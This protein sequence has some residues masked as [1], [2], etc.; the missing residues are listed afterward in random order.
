MPS[1]LQSSAS[2][3]RHVADVSSRSRATELQPRLAR[4]LR[5]LILREAAM[6]ADARHAVAPL[7]PGLF[8]RRALKEADRESARRTREAAASCEELEALAR[9]AR[10][11]VLGEPEIV[12]VLGVAT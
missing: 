8:D 11:E 9:A 1:I 7:Q 4:S 5:H 3:L 12:L 2:R 6:Q 10:V